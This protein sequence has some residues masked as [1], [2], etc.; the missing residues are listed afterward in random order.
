MVLGNNNL[1]NKTKGILFPFLP[2]SY[3]I[4]ATLRPNT[5][6]RSFVVETLSCPCAIKKKKKRAGSEI[7]VCRLFFHFSSPSRQILTRTWQH[8][9][10]DSPRAEGQWVRSAGSCWRYTTAQQLGHPES[11][12][13]IFNGFQKLNH[14]S[15]FDAYPMPWVEEVAVMM[16]RPS[17]SRRTLHSPNCNFFK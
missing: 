11:I 4:M 12:S 15:K 14:I 3:M 5:H 1:H 6:G 9:P 16:K 13:R 8:N 2:L 7:A 10:S 17:L